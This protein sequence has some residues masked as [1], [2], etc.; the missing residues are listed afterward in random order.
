M[1]IAI[2]R[3]SWRDGSAR[4]LAVKVTTPNPRNAKNVSA[5]LETMCRGAGYS[6]GASSAGSRFAIVTA[7]NTARMPTTTK[8]ITLW[9]LA[10]SV[11]P[12]TFSAVIATTIATANGF[13]HAG[14]PPAKLA[15]A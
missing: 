5:T 9:I 7:A 4:S 14:S 13:S 15:L 11:D 12:A 1:A 2:A 3:G 8:T 6:E 10:T